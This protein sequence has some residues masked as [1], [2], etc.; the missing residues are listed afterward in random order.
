MIVVSV[1]VPA[2]GVPEDDRSR[3]LGSVIFLAY[4]AAVSKPRSDGDESYYNIPA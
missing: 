1:K 3:N 4:C 2:E